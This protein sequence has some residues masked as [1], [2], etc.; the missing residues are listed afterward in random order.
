MRRIS[1]GTAAVIAVCGGVTTAVVM[2]N[3]L[4]AFSDSS[5][6]WERVTNVAFYPGKLVDQL[7]GSD[8][9]SD[10][11][12]FLYAVL[13][14]LVFFILVSRALRVLFSSRHRKAL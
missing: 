2:R 9:A 5:P 14:A 8:V 3:V 7:A 4:F 10:I 12:L 11:N 13:F 1:L 6:A